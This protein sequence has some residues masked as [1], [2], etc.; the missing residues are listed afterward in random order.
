MFGLAWRTG[1]D[2]ASRLTAY[3]AKRE[4]HNRKLADAAYREWKEYFS[5]AEKYRLLCE[6]AVGN[7]DD[8][9]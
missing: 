3:Y 1:M 4:A 7:G 2:S 8:R 6:E 9:L 5:L